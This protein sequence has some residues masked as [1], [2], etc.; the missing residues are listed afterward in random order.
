MKTLSI[1]II[2]AGIV[3]MSSG[4]WAACGY[5]QVGCVTQQDLYNRYQTQESLNRMR[6]N[7]QRTQDQLNYQAEQLR[8]YDQQY[9]E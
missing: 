7:M 1:I 3:L 8:Q 2:S 4:S 5:G 9:G 6:D